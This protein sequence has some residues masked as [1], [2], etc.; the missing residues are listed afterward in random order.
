MS[1]SINKTKKIP[2][3]EI[4]GT[5]YRGKTALQKAWMCRS[6][7]LSRGICRTLNAKQDGGLTRVNEDD[8]RWYLKAAWISEG[9]IRKLLYPRFASSLEEVLEGTSV[10]VGRSDFLEEGRDAPLQRCV[11]FAQEI[12]KETSRFDQAVAKSNR[13]HRVHKSL[14]GMTPRKGSARVTSMKGKLMARMRKDIRSQISAFRKRVQVGGHIKCVLCGRQVSVAESHMDH[15]TGAQSFSSIAER[16]V[17]ESVKFADHV[18]S[19][20]P[21][22][23][24]S[25][26][27]IRILYVRDK[28]TQADWK[29]FHQKHAALAPT[30]TKCN[31]KQGNN[32]D[33]ANL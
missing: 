4:D 27:K 29:D 23:V 16:F 8:R 13:V 3:F 25:W 15:G 18:Q 2:V 5:R 21:P 20:E 17:T 24:N 11:F 28:V 10:L 31:L 12:Q 33:I 30:C 6:A 7:L 9:R 19:T 1:C 26:Y 32:R 14:V 22:C